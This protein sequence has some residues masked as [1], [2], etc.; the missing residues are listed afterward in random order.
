M[1]WS[2][3]LQAGL[4]FVAFG[5]SF[6]AFEAQLNRMTGTDDGI[7]DGLFQFS[8]VLNSA[9]YWCPPVSQG[10]LNLAAINS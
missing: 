9:Y 8:Q 6:D 5:R 3:K 10:K 2:I 4:M 7:E 1:P